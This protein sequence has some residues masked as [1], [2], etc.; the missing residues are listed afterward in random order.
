MCCYLE[1]IYG[2]KFLVID[3]DFKINYTF[4]QYLKV[5]KII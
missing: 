2:T 4:L 3:S 1:Y 5:A